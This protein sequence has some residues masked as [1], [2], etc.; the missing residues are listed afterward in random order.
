[1][2][3]DE[4]LKL[5]MKRRS[6]RQFKPDPVPDELVD[7][8]IEAARW[9]P[10]GANSQPWEFVVVKDPAVKEKLVEIFRDAAENSNKLGQTR[11]PEERHPADNRSPHHPGFQDAPVFIILFGDPRVNRTFPLSAYSY[12]RDSIFASGMAS[13]ILYMHLAATSL[14]LASQWV[15]S[16]AQPLSQALT[17]QLLGVPPVYIL[18]DMVALGYGLHEPRP[19]LVRE[20]KEIVHFDHFDMAKYRSDEM[21]T[22]YID[23]VH[24]NRATI[25]D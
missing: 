16:F 2:N 19:R 3:Y 15:T 11:P 12:N 13:A 6:M 21:I 22:K 4:F 20:K 1:M 14:G 5:A 23:A 7:K 9:A 10:S 18:Y 8:I 24:K 25:P 17:K